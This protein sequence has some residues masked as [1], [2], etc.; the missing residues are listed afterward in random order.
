MAREVDKDS[1]IK[2][3]ELS[4]RSQSEATRKYYKMVVD[5]DTHIDRLNL[6][7]ESLY[8]E[9][10]RTKQEVE[11]AQSRLSTNHKYVE[12]WRLE[13][14]IVGNELNKLQHRIGR[15]RESNRAMHRELKELRERVRELEEKS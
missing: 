4:L 14:E 12:R 2:G 7:N 15:Q 9:L 8:K 6:E 1:K 3:L 13:R 11:Q 5:K 10:R